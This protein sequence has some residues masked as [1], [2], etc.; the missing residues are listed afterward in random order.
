MTQI[1]WDDIQ[2]EYNAMN[3]MSCVPSGI[4]KVRADQIGRAHV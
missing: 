1:E 4:R 3:T 2:S